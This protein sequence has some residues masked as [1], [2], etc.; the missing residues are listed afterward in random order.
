MVGICFEMMN[1]EPVHTQIH[2]EEKG[3]PVPI[4]L[5]RRARHLELLRL[6]C[7]APIVQLHD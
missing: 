3:L 4:P 1:D 2:L 7:Y 6:I 5:C